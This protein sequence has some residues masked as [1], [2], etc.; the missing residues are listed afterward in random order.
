MPNEMEDSVFVSLSIYLVLKN[1]Y[2]SKVVVE[3]LS[4]NIFYIV[5]IF[6]KDFSY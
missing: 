4:I 1:H 6:A 5:S 2:V 3:C